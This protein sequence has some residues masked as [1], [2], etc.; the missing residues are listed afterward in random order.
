MYLNETTRHADVILPPPSQLQRRHYDVSLL[1]L[2]IRNVANYS[3]PVL[4][5]DDGQPD[6][7]E[8]IAKL[9]L[10]RAGPRRRRRSGRGRRRDDR[11]AGPAATART[12][13]RTSQGGTP[14]NC[15]PNST[16]RPARARAPARRHAPHRAVRRRI[17]VEPGRDVAR[18]PA[19][20]SP[21]PRLRRRSS[22][23]CPGCCA[24]RAARSS[25]R[26]PV[27]IGDLARLEAADRRAGGE[28]PGA[29]RST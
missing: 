22:S 11:R 18:R 6:E 14:T 16:R 4:P 7:W 1:Q 24:R 12:S 20:S 2:A 25:W 10:D 13:T 26:P 19:R 5:L 28:G 29:R 8:I 15:S 21:R 9:A 17:R 3:E 23:G 27:L